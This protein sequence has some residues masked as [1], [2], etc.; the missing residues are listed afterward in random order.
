MCALPWPF[1][2]NCC[3]CRK[4]FQSGVEPV[5]DIHSRIFCCSDCAWAFLFREEAE[6]AWR[7]Q[8]CSNH[9]YRSREVHEQPRRNLDITT[10]YVSSTAPPTI[11]A[12]PG[13]TDCSLDSV[14]QQMTT[15]HEPA[16]SNGNAV[17]NVSHEGSGTDIP[18]HAASQG[19]QSNS[20]QPTEAHLP[21]QTEK[22]KKYSPSD[23]VPS[24]S[25]HA[26]FDLFCNG[27]GMC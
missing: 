17:E 12:A 10:S 20:E 3:N 19:I 14:A 9:R 5:A 23:S 25:S 1:R 4:G 11:Q 13:P 27:G 24:D 6:T 2:S 22:L 8:L 16:E 21:S 15:D 7:S 26:L 18:A